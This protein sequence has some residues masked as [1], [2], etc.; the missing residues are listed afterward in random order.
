MTRKIE[1]EFEYDASI[2]DVWN[3]LTEA[4]HLK[5]WFAPYAD[6]NA[7]PDG[8]IS[9]AWREDFSEEYYM[10][11][12]TFE[13]WEAPSHLVLN[14]HAAPAG[15]EPIRLPVEF[16]LSEKDGRTKLSL[17][18]SGFLDDESWDDEYLSHSRGWQY[19]LRSLGYYLENFFGRTRQMFKG[20]AL[21]GNTRLEDIVGPAGIFKC[22]SA[23]EIGETFS[24]VLPDG[25]SADCRL[26]Y[27]RSVLD[28][29]FTCDVLEEG[30]VRICLETMSSE[31]TL[32]FWVFSWTMAQESVTQLATPWYERLVN[33]LQV[34]DTA[35]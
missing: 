27:A 20:K 16:K 13:A 12:M 9:L 32:M 18:Q 4:E 15:V 17:V 8:F 10:P 24:L 23:P 28:F 5:N 31:P 29:V 6:S 25:R 22:G 33:E 35:A 19:E 30:L 3:A 34:Q 11:Q 21:L 1:C 2:E 14:W 7:G 26:L